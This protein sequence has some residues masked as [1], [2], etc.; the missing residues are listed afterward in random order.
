MKTFKSLLSAVLI[1]IL[2]CT[3]SVSAFAYNDVDP[4]DESLAAIEFVD[5]LGIIPSTWNGDFRPEQYFSRADAVMAAYK[6]L[7]GEAI[8]PTVYE[9]TG[10]PFNVSSQGDIEDGSALASYLMWAAD[11]Y[12]ITTNTGSSLFR[13]AQAVTA[14]ELMT[15]L[16]KLT[17]LVQDAE[18]TYPDAYVEAFSELA[19]DMEAGETPVTRKQ[20]AVAIANALVCDEEGKAGEIGVYEDY[21]G[22]PLTSLAV[23]AQHMASIDLV[24]RATTNRNLGYDVKNGTLLSNGM[25]VDLGND[26]SDYVGYSINI[27]YRDNDN[28]KT[29]T[30]DEPILAYSVGS[31]AS[32]TVPF[33][34]V[35]V[36]AGNNIAVE[37]ESSVVS[38]NTSTYLY[39]NDN[40]WP[41]GDLTYDLT[42]L[43]DSLGTSDFVENRPNFQFKCMYEAESSVLTAVFATEARPAKIV[44]VNNGIYSV[45][46]YYKASSA[47][48]VSHYNVTDCVFSGTVKVGD[49]VNFYESDGKCYFTPGTTI[50]A[51]LDAKQVIVGSPTEYVLK[52]GTILREHSFFTYGNTNLVSGKEYLF[53]V[54]DSGENYMLS[55]EKYQTNHAGLFVDSIVSDDAKAIHTITAT[56]PKT[57]A[58]VKFDV[59]YENVDSSTA[60]VAGDYINYSD[61]GA[62]GT[63]PEGETPKAL[64]VFVKKSI[65][66]KTIN[67]ITPAG[68]TNYIVD[69]DTNEIY[70]KNQICNAAPE[71][72]TATIVLDLAETIIQII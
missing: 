36:N 35:K 67:Y 59:T 15:L 63:A 65:T 60:I 43:V 29:L 12:L 52:D 19:G 41:I 58:Q 37:V 64:E 11:N 47:D 51:E 66:K 23:K 39:L 28:S 4:S 50:T 16:A 13:P 56:N 10:L 34:S 3:L 5:R 44:G 26:L 18:A 68:A 24:V 57:N 9:S 1:V 17:R 45:F 14:N 21:D 53:I 71:S 69:A 61:N 31:A 55:W 22:V 2:I 46:D 32:A 20:A 27:T 38:L 70:Y 49:F 62:D 48:A 6:M 54:E 30:D 42:T 33:S 7:Y 40:P 8:D 72:G 25:D